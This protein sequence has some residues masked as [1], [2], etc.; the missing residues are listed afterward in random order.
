MAPLS[1][2]PGNVKEWCFD[3]YHPYPGGTPMLDFDETTP[4][5]DWI[6]EA[7]LKRE[8]FCVRGGGWTKQTA[9]IRN[10]YRDAD[11]TGRWFFRLGFRTVRAV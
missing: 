6:Q 7:A 8:L 4:D 9:N 11:G 2:R 10:T 3:E 5:L 1:A